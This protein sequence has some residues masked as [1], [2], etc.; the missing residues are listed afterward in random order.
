MT[1]LD[2]P[3]L[4]GR[5]N[6]KKKPTEVVHPFFTQC[7]LSTDDA[8]WKSFFMK[9]SYNIFPKGFLYRDSVLTFRHRNKIKRLDI[10]ADPEQA[11]KEITTFMRTHA[12]I[13]SEVERA[14]LRE[15]EANMFHFR[16]EEATWKEVKS[17]KKLYASVVAHFVG[18]MARQY[19]LDRHGK[20]SF[21]R[22][23]Y[24]A[25]A[26]GF[27]TKIIFDRGRIVEMPGVV[28][29]PLTRTFSLDQEMLDGL[30][31]QMERSKTSTRS[32]TASRKRMEVTPSSTSF[33][34]LEDDDESY[35]LEE[36]DEEVSRSYEDED[37]E[38]EGDGDKSYP[39]ED[40][41]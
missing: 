12:G 36:E 17:N 18:R 39:E 31:E 33:Q 22:V 10:S 13:M 34:E 25:L 27:D 6:A 14:Q 16:L 21:S 37:C 4:Q 15:R 38:G 1:N 19:G 26:L 35:A 24:T 28:W 9:A 8:T 32:S 7:M 3:L 23:V 41:D 29:D 11:M 20:D 2:V 30:L 5:R 40:D